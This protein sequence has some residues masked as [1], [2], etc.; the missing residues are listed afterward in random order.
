VSR[1]H[2]DGDLA[3]EEEIVWRSYLAEEEEIVWRS[4]S[5]WRRK[6]RRGGGGDARWRRRGGW[7]RWRCGC[8]SR[9]LASL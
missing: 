8:R 4:S 1:G 7:R 9:E 3:E 2:T 6:R 5:R